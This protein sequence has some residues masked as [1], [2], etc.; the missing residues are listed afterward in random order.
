MS[1]KNRKFGRNKKRSPSAARYKAE[2]RADKNKRL[3]VEREAKRQRL[4]AE[5]RKASDIPIRGRA[6]WLRR[7]ADGT[8]KIQAAA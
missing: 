8:T 6:R 3:N 7:L 2:N 4:Y 1:G 5:R